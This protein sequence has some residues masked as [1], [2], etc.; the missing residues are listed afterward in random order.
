MRIREIRNCSNR[1]GVRIFEHILLMKG[2]I[3]REDVRKFLLEQFLKKINKPAVRS[4]CF[5]RRRFLCFIQ[6]FLSSV[7]SNLILI[8]GILLMVE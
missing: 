7:G 4:A 2:K 3:C 5:L 6:L 1:N 8:F